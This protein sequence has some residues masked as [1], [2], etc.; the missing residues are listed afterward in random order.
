MLLLRDAAR[1]RRP[2]PVDTGARDADGLTPLQLAASSG[3]VRAAARLNMIE[4]DKL[5]PLNKD[6]LSAEVHAAARSGDLAEL[7]R[8]IRADANIFAS[9][10]EGHT[11][12]MRAARA[13]NRDVVLRLLL[14]GADPINRLNWQWD[15]PALFF[16]IRNGDDDLSAMLL[17]TGASGRTMGNGAMQWTAS[18]GRADIIRLLLDM[19]SDRRFNVDTRNYPG[20]TPLHHAVDFEHERIVEILL[21]S[22]R[23][24]ERARRP[25][26][27]SRVG[28]GRRPNDAATA[29]SST[30]CSPP[31]R[32]PERAQ[33]QATSRGAPATR[34]RVDWA[35][36]FLRDSYAGSAAIHPM[37]KGVAGQRLEVSVALTKS[38]FAKYRVNEVLARRDDEAAGGLSAFSY[39]SVCGE[40]RKAA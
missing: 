5:K 10:G 19:K 40:E 36:P 17:L 12:L 28:D 25:D 31:A 18:F 27:R 6:H 3:H 22:G 34:S 32:R 38:D 24:P 16:T 1:W 30:W 21:D 23:G 20:Q 33:L 8:L 37:L 14:A 13:G 29:R 4:T 39:W 35:S 11:P 26:I 7:E 15:E 2:N 9:D